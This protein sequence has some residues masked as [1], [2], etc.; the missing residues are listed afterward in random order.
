MRDVAREMVE[1]A[2]QGLRN[3]ARLNAQGE[4]ETKYLAPLLDI[5]HGAPTQAEHW[6]ARFNGPWRGDVTRIF[7]EAAI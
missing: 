4:D 2:M 7:A 6:L 5:I 1:L 3:R